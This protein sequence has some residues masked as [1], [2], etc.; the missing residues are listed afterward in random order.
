MGY[1]SVGLVGVFLAGMA[2]FFSPCI[3]PVIP[4][5]LAYITG[6]RVDSLQKGEIYRKAALWRGLAFVVGFSAIFIA[7]GATATYVGQ[8]LF[9]N[10]EIFLHVGG[11]IVFLAGLYLAGLI[12]LAG[13]LKERRIRYVPQRIGM[14][15]PVLLGMAFAFGWTPC[16][17]PI[18]SSIL[19]FAAQGQTVSTGIALLGIYSVG[20][21]VPFLISAVAVD[22]V[23]PLLRSVSKYLPWVTKAAG[24]ILMIL[25]ILLFFDMLAVVTF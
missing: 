15:T 16:V 2:S 10:R 19:V 22:K 5:Y 23:A 7:L 6:V 3:V 11:A 21:S 24:I 1:E 25:G 12:P 13:L 14:Y 4:A 17:G 20:L 8:L 9:I 18:L